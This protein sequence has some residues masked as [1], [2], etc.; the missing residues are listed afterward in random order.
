MRCLKCTSLE[1]RVLDTRVNKDGTSIRR[2]RECLKCGHRYTTT[3]EI[4]REGL[5]VLKRDGRREEFN[6]VKMLSGIS[7]ACEKR[8]VDVE[9]LR[10]LVTDVTTL[11]QDKYDDEIPS[12]EIGEEIMRKLREIDKVAYVRFASV[13]KDFR[14]INEFMLEISRMD[15]PGA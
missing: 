10:M 3:E 1:D 7:R 4:L 11:L 2:R 15:A 9:Q 13:Y 5:T 12:R 8:P 14:D 6:R